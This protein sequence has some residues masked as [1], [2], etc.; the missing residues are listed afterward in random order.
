MVIVMGD[1]NAKI[2]SDNE[3]YEAV[4][5]KEGLGEMYD[6][7]ERFADFCDIRDLVIGGGVFLRRGVHGA[8]WRHPNCTVENQIDHIIY[9]RRFRR[10][11][12]DVRVGRGATV[13]SA[14]YLVVG[15]L[16]LK[17]KKNWAERPQGRERFNTTLLK[18]PAKR[19]EFQFTLQTGFRLWR[20]SRMNHL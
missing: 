15:S 14:Q 18:D 9:S 5:E 2:G 19:N 10:C 6:D 1:L 3:G 16:K 12:S 13:G 4:L 11:I 17:L 7:G 20:T 8:T